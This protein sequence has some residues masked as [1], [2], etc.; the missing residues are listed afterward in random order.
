[1]FKVG[2]DAHNLE[3][4]RAGV[5]RY[6]QNILYEFSRMPELRSGARFVLYFKKDIP[7]DIFL[8]NPLFELRSLRT[9]IR[10]SFLFYFLFLLP[11]VAW[12]DKVDILWFPG[13]MVPHTWR[14]RAVLTLHDPS[15]EREPKSV[16]MRY[17]IPY[18]LFGR[19]G[20]KHSI[21][22]LTVSEFSKNEIIDIYK[23]NSEKVVVTPL[24]ANEMFRVVEDEAALRAVKEKYGINDKFVMF[25]GQIFNR[26]HVVEALLAYAKIARNFSDVQFLLLGPDR[27]K[28]KPIVNEI[29]R[30]INER[31]GR[32]AV[33]RG[34]FAPL[35]D[36][37]LLDNAAEATFYMSDYEGFGLPPL[38][39]LA[40]GTPVLA[41]NTTALAT[42][43]GGNQI[44]VENPKDIN[45]IAGKLR[46]ILTDTEYRKQ[47]RKSGP[48]WA[49]QFSW[50]RTAED[51][52]KTLF[53]T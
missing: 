4:D 5:G 14:G 31:L 16:S 20:V 41:L 12:R 49:S 30:R 3:A 48:K 29:A 51:T 47:V 37:V 7:T 17:Y 40:C 33:V 36:M 34:S 35:D 28:P 15:Y 2:V 32:K 8:R 53:H 22:V 44:V 9:P 1:M 6:L 45:E 25:A 24:A 52:L 23:C 18:R 21:K 19:Y 50:K 46:N 26:R 42:T 27:T 10:S 11:I 39:S 43:L 38:E 13:Y